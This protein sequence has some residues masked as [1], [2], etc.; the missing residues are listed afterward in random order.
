MEAAKTLAALNRML[1]AL[2]LV[3]PEPLQKIDI[4][5]EIRAIAEER[6]AVR[7]AKN[8]AQSD[9]LRDLLEERGWLVK[10]GKNGYELSPR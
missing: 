2:G 8:W 6:Q 1:G 9:V 10:D 5:A 4:P 7:Q 3:L